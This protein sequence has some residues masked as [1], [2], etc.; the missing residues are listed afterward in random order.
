MVRKQ[1]VP[2]LTPLAIA[3]LA[4]LE[5]SPMHPYE[6]YQLLMNR[7]EDELVKIKPGSLYHT[8]A[9]LAEQQL[10]LAEGTDR[11][12]NRPE[13]TTYRIRAAGREALRH[14]IAEILRKPVKEYPTFPVAM[15]EA[16]NLP[17]DEVIVLL[18]ERVTWLDGN[19]AEYLALQEFAA[20][21]QVPRRFWM[22]VEYLQA[23]AVTEA[24][25]LRGII[26]DLESGELEWEPYD[27]ET[28]ER[29]AAPEVA[30]GHDWG[31]GLSDA[32]LNAVRQSGE[33]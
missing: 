30:L 12:G 9:R 28:G 32:D 26:A 5:E 24:T 19:N 4:L 10:V 1:A 18:R 33:R 15:A 27:P 6:M 13:R 31:A 20:K 7:H 11:A 3:V 16:H 14:R 2:A 23:Q 25:W 29:C 22:V 21:R 17:V 8:V